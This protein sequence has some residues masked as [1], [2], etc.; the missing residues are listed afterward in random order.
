MS[1]RILIVYDQEE[2]QLKYILIL[3]FVLLTFA[4]C[5][6]RTV[7]SEFN[8]AN[9]EPLPGNPIHQGNRV[10]IK[11]LEPKLNHLPNDNEDVSAF[12]RQLYMDFILTGNSFKRALFPKRSRE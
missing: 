10:R 2:V 4:S 12:R 1:V 8:F 7:Q 5:S 6:T 11:T 9:F 3:S